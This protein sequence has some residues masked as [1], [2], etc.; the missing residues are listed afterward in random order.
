[1]R[2]AMRSRDPWWAWVLAFLFLAA[3]LFFWQE[4]QREGYRACMESN[5]NHAFCDALRYY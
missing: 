2:P 3:M 4:R 5:H 1:M